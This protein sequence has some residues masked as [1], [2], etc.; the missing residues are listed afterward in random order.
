M[1]V[2][3]ELNTKVIDKNQNIWVIFPGRGRKYFN[4]FY[5]EKKIFLDLPGTLFDERVNEISMSQYRKQEVKDYV[6]KNVVRSLKIQEWTR[7]T[8][9]EIFP[10]NAPSKNLDDFPTRFPEEPKNFGSIVST[11]GKFFIGMKH[12]DLVLVPGK[13]GA[14]SSVHFGELRGGFSPTNSVRLPK[15]REERAQARNVNWLGVDASRV[16][17]SRDVY[18]YLTRPPAIH[19]ISDPKAKLEVYGTAYKNYIV[20]DKSRALVFAKE[21]DGK[22]PTAVNPVN[23]AVKF[24]V[25][26][27]NCHAQQ[28]AHELQKITDIKAFS[29]KYYN[30]D[31]LDNYT[32]DFH[33]PGQYGIYPREAALSLFLSTTMALSSGIGLSSCHGE[34]IKLENNMSD[35]IK[36]AEEY[37]PHINELIQTLSPEAKQQVDELSNE[38]KAQIGL[39]TPLVV[40]K[41]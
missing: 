27:Y 2:V 24:L 37:E 22:D 30:P 18:G 41:N 1:A 29:E 21:Y 13:G 10:T 40:K 3:V 26:V 35:Q 6:R 36:G 38:A 33:S 28:N 32:L 8:E 5:D 23:D 15:F 4:R 39:T 9:T 7:E 20:G 17:F 19:Q 14:F 25:A 11:A 16:D 12:G 31:L 34:T